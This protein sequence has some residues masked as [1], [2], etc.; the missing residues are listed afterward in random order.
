MPRGAGS[1]WPADGSVTAELA[2]VLPVV[3]LLLIAGL[4]VLVATTTQLRCVDAAREAA[5]AA[6]R[7]DPAAVAIGRRVAPPGATV[8]VGREGDLIRVTVSAPLPTIGRAWPGQVS[9]AAVAEA[10]PVP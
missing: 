9:A 2:T 10:E 1:R 4:T 6:S 8:R 7:G 3:V 5:R